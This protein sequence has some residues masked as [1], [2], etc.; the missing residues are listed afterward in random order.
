MK[1]PAPPA[2]L[3]I[4]YAARGYPKSAKG[5]W[6]RWQDGTYFAPGQ[7]EFHQ[8]GG[9]WASG[10]ALFAVVGLEDG[11]WL[12]GGSI[13]GPRYPDRAAALAAAVAEIVKRVGFCV[14]GWE[15]NGKW[16][17]PGSMRMP[18]EQGEAIIAWASEIAGIPPA[19]LPER[20][21]LNAPPKPDHGPLFA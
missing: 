4:D 16:C 7:G 5:D 11:T 21:P 10:E 17:P 18:R 1:R 3:P 15:V 2:P 9:Q 14:L 12:A 6:A 8:L 20:H 19:V 13:H